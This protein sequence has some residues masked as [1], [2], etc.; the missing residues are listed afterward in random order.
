MQKIAFVVLAF[1]GVCVFGGPRVA[2]QD[3]SS[4]PARAAAGSAEAFADQQ[5]ALLRK[6][7]R[8]IKETTHRR[9]F[10]SRG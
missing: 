3:A 7:I 9:E 6:D 5:F 2:A 10:D 4:E 8:S 1:I